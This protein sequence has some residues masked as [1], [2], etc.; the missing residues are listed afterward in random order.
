MPPCNLSPY[1]KKTRNISDEEETKILELVAILKKK[2]ER[3]DDYEQE[4]FRRFLELQ[5]PEFRQKLLAVIKEHIQETNL[6]DSFFIRN[7][8][9][10]RPQT[11]K[12]NKVSKITEPVVKDEPK[13]SKR[14]TYKDH[15]ANIAQTGSY[16]QQ[17]ETTEIDQDVPQNDGN[18]SDQLN[19]RDYERVSEGSN[20]Q[21]AY[22]TYSD[23]RARPHIEHTYQAKQAVP[24]N[25]RHA[26]MVKRRLD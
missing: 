21:Y 10:R 9:V 19:D 6:V 25:S 23:H 11:A 18:N 24:V 13:M 26:K 8:P 17:H 16:I 3:W 5:D 2:V 7:K 20:Y 4:K 1:L 15:A 22:E 12:P 14:V